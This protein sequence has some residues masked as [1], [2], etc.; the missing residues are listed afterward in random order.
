[1]SSQLHSVVQWSKVHSVVQRSKI[2]L[3]ELSTSVRLNAGCTYSG[4]NDIQPPSGQKFRVRTFD[5]SAI[6]CM[7]YVRWK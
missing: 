6:K 3:S 7:L 4:N 5:H 1:M 2:P